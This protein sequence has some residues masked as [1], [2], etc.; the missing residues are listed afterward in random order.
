MKPGR[1]VIVGGSV[2]GVFAG[3]MLVQRG[4][5][6]DILERAVDALVSRGTGIG[7][8]DELEALLAEL[9]LPPGDDAG[10]VVDGRTGFD[11]TGRLF[12]EYAY[13]Q[14][15]TAWNKVF[16]PLY[17]AFPRAYY[18]NGAT[19]TAIEQDK[20]GAA[21]RTADGRTFEGDI[22]IGAD[23]FGSVVRATV[24]PDKVPEYAGY[25]A[26]RGINDSTDL[27]AD[28][29]ANRERL[30]AYV[31]VKKGQFIGY[32]LTGLDGTTDVTTR[33]YNYLWYYPMDDAALAN[34]LTDADG[35]VHDYGIP[36]SK[37]RP[38]P[39]AAMKEDAYRYVPD[40]FIELVERAHTTMVQ[41][42][43]EVDCERMVYDNLVLIGDA[44]HVV[45][46]H[47]GTGV[48]KAGQDAR[49]LAC[50]L[51][52]GNTLT[53]A[54]AQ[55]EAARLDY[56]RFLAARSKLLGSYIERRLDD[57]ADDPSLELTRE[58]IMRISGRPPPP[59]L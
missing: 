19:V 18:H 55:F 43:Y 33:R 49:A 3:N 52:A 2:A 15:L 38:E 56:N 41:P 14:R 44:A 11:H 32:P 39:V 54:L 51:E 25:V 47:V 22:V 58:R 5:Q 16:Q 1:A 27:S 31:F 4:W 17:D 10:I 12:Y 45:R 59:G 20:G 48:L 8:H 53:D 24:A 6:V 30:Y 46:P 50:A 29:V 57:P 40:N 21:A 42:I 23:G 34:V 36:P 9:G 28:F 26:W 13:W 35:V 7:R 37:L